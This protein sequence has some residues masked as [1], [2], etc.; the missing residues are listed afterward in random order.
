MTPT[1]KR[2]PGGGHDVLLDGVLAGTVEKGWT[3]SGGHGFYT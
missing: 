3:R 2:S 1:V